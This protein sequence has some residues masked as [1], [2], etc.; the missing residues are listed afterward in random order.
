MLIDGVYETIADKGALLLPLYCL[1]IE[2]GN[3]IVCRIGTADVIDAHQ[4]CDFRPAPHIGAHGGLSGLSHPVHPH[5]GLCIPDDAVIDKNHCRL[6]APVPGY[7]PVHPD[8]SGVPEKDAVRRAGRTLLQ[9]CTCLNHFPR[10][11]ALLLCGSRLPVLFRIRGDILPA[12]CGRP[13]CPCRLLCHPAGTKQGGKAECR[14]AGDDASFLNAPGPSQDFSSSLW[15][16]RVYHLPSPQ[17]YGRRPEGTVT[18]QNHC[19][20]W[21]KCGTAHR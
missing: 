6:A 1:L 14:R 2:P 20:M 16:P 4:H 10:H 7:R 19:E 21:V 15:V 5:P 17:R 3:V 11:G 18:T 13:L 12:C 9:C 8:G